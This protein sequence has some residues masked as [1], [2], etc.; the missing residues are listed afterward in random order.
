M[1][2]FSGAKDKEV[3]NGDTI[4]LKVSKENKKTDMCTSEVIWC[5]VFS[6]M[7]K[8]INRSQTWVIL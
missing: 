4:L 2:D 8:L 5:V 3:F 6:L 1:T 7:L